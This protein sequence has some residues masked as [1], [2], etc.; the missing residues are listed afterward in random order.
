MSRR[1]FGTD[2]VR[3]TY[4][5]ALVNEV[6][7]AR[8]AQAVSTFFRRRNPDVRRAIVGRDTRASG[9][10]LASAIIAALTERSGLE[11]YDAGIAPT[12]A[13][14]GSIAGLNAG[15]A[16]VVTASHNP[17]CDNGFKVFGGGGSK[18]TDAD[19]HEIE[20]LLDEPEMPPA[21]GGSV[22]RTEVADRYAKRM[23]QMLPPGSLEGWRIVVDAANGATAATTPKVLAELGADLLMVGH[24]PNGSNINENVGAQHPET[25]AEAVRASGARLGIA[26][27][28]DGD[29]VVFCDET[30]SV[31]DGDDILAIVATRALETGELRKNTVVATVQSNLGLD[32]AIR[33]AGGEVVRTHVGDRYVIE[34]MLRDGYN[35]GGETSG[36]VVLL[37][38]SPTG[39]GLAS[40]MKVLEIMYAR[41]MPLSRLRQC[42]QRFPQLSASLPVR[43]RIPLQKLRQVPGAIAEA[44]AA[45][46]SAGRV[47]VRYSG[48]ELLL[49]LLVE[50]RD[51]GQVE[52]LF[53]RLRSAAA[54]ELGMNGS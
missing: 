33:D 23:L 20:A 17:A 48:T 1:Y 16:I 52:D 54:S 18:L 43:E 10:S 39:D 41:R 28:G 51:R 21:A 31:L 47:L 40:A 13:I 11:I 44:E 50:G 32:Q 29:R 25:M 14:A 3:G 7:A 37:D 15:F 12:P 38:H 2:G 42:W 4:G 19:E 49:R 9:E 22:H 6:F 8:F 34:R 5:S 30:G 35:V 26:H 45:L 53:A 27:D 36:H 46:G 24:L